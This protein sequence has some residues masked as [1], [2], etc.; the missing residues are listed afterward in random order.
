ML[1]KIL[2]AGYYGAGNVGDE[3]LLKTIL[4]WIDRSLYIPY[5]ITISTDYT[6]TH[7]NVNVVHN[8]DIVSLV[9]L[10]QESCCL[11]FGGGGLIQDHHP[12][13]HAE[14]NNFFAFSNVHYIRLAL[15]ADQFALPIAILGNGIGPLRSNES[16]ELAK[17]FF[18]L[19]QLITLR[20][21]ESY[22]LLKKMSIDNQQEPLIA[23]DI[24]FSL[25]NTDLMT[26]H[27]P[28]N[29]ILSMIDNYKKNNYSI[30]GINIREWPFDTTWSLSLLQEQLKVK[31]DKVFYIF[32]PFQNTDIDLCTQ[33]SNELNKAGKS[34]LVINETSITSM[35]NYFTICDLIIAMRY[36]GVLMAHLLKTPC[37]AIEYD[38]KVSH[39][40]AQLQFPHDYS[41]KVENLNGLANAID[42]RLTDLNN[43]VCNDKILEDLHT[44]ALQH[45]DAL[46]NFIKLASEQDHQINKKIDYANL[47]LCQ[48]FQRDLSLA[49]SE[50][51]YLTNSLSWKLTQP[52]R[53]IYSFIKLLKN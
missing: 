38:D 10:M 18:D 51:A 40:L 9:S 24:V 16:L 34:S 44:K 23:P 26:P 28:S 32:L 8:Y 29:H 14:L 22:H 27:V 36:H 4:S 17:R 43:K 15:L 7:H 52:L 20:D 53:K 25:L 30:V 12:A 33:L 35:V 3:L 48:S 1:K 49:K 50:I 19:A 13:N 39:L 6:K 47:Y 37:I 21:Y 31:E 11:I 2:I 45:K 46:I 5:V 42:L 41:F